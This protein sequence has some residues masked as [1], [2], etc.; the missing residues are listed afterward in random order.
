LTLVAVH[1]IAHKPANSTQ[2]MALANWL[3]SLLLGGL[4]V[5]VAVSVGYRWVAHVGLKRHVVSGS[6]SGGVQRGDAAHWPVGLRRPAVD[7]AGLLF[8]ARSICRGGAT[9]DTYWHCTRQRRTSDDWRRVMF[10]V[11]TVAL[12]SALAPQIMG[13][14][15]HLLCRVV[16]TRRAY[17]HLIDL[18]YL[19]FPQ[20]GEMLFLYMRLWGAP[21]SSLMH[22]VFAGPTTL[23]VAGEGDGCGARTPVYFA[24]IFLSAETV[25]LEASWPYVDLMLAFYTL[26]AT[27]CVQRWRVHHKSHDLILTG[28]MAGLAIATKY[29]AVSLVGGLLLALLFQPEERRLRSMAIVIGVAACR[30]WYV[31]NWLR[32]ATCFTQCWGWPLLGCDS[33]KVS[34]GPGWPRRRGDLDSAGYESRG[35]R[36]A[37]L[38][39]SGHCF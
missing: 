19:G 4:V 10:V 18:P 1:F 30:D 39:P 15:G 37:I 7:G 38:R 20:F 34:V 11:L 31:K 36:S 25:V 28:A 29:S 6:G 22:W 21:P 9:Y 13:W 8:G 24:A 3:P 26:A 17:C 5:A 14:L 27:V 12:S 23:L 2:L 35:R 16:L 33:V 32:K